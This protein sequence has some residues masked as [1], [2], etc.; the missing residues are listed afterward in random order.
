MEKC[1]Y[2]W[3]LCSVIDFLHLRGK[4]LSSVFKYLCI[5]FNF[6]S[7]VFV[8]LHLLVML[9]ISFCNWS[10][11]AGKPTQ[12]YWFHETYLKLQVQIKHVSAYPR[13]CFFSVKAYGEGEIDRSNNWAV[14]EVSWWRNLWQLCLDKNVVE[15][16]SL[17]SARSFRKTFFIV[18]LFC[19]S[20]DCVLPVQILP[21]SIGGL[22]LLPMILWLFHSEFHPLG[23]S[24]LLTRELDTYYPSLD[25][26]FSHL[27]L[28]G[29]V[30]RRI[31]LTL[32]MG[33]RSFCWVHM[34]TL[35]V[36]V[37][38][39]V[40]HVSRAELEVFL[41]F[42]TVR[43]WFNVYKISIVRVRVYVHVYVHIFE[44]LILSVGW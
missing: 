36:A 21:C 6:L 40:R 2:K 11:R 37:K 29:S 18:L 8:Q 32:S 15:N 44:C 34:L 30:L 9:F 17:E 4:I 22:L 3:C 26:N 19:T 23:C 41:L 12:E 5:L 25:L 42:F 38:E 28:F 10:N 31:F 33:L 43:G 27:Y 7:T 13:R 16:L 14:V 1:F 20:E 24:I 35:S 39:S